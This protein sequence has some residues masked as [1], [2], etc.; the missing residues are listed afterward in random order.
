MSYQFRSNHLHVKQ[1]G[2]DDQSTPPQ[3]PA[4]WFVVVDDDGEILGDGATAELAQIDFQRGRGAGSPSP[5][6][7]AALKRKRRQ[8]RQKRLKRLERLQGRT[9]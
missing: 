2:L 1:L 8:R 6:A 3:Y 7:E 4:P 9:Q 5:E